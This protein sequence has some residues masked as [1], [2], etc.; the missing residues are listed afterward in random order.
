MRGGAYDPAARRHLAMRTGPGP[1]LDLAWVHGV[2][3][4][5][6]CQFE[7]YRPALPST[8]AREWNVRVKGNIHDASRPAVPGTPARTTPTLSHMTEASAL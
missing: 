2:G 1:G 6:Q 8:R 5:G 7:A 4:S 3:T